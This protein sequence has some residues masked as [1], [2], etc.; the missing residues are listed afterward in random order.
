M[1]YA[2][3]AKFLSRLDIK[4]RDSHRSVKFNFKFNQQKLHRIASQM[5]D[6]GRPVRLLVDKARRVTC[7]SWVEGISFCHS[8]AIPGAHSL[9]VAHEFKTSKELF[10]V[11][12][13]FLSSVP[14]LGIEAIEREIR[15]PHPD[16]PSVMQIVTAGKSTSGRG[17]T[18]SLLH[19]SE[20]AHYES[21]DAF[22]SLLPALSNHR[23]TVGVIESTPNGREGKG[24]AF[25][26]MY[27]DAVEG[28]SSWRAVFLSWTDDPACILDETL[29]ADAP[30]DDEE[31]ELM[32]RGL[33]RA[34]LAWRR[35]KISTE[36]EGSVS[37]FH[38]EYPTTDT[39]SFIASGMPAFEL[40][41]INWARK[42]VS[43]PIRTG[44]LE[45]STD[46]TLAFRAHRDG[47]LRIW[48]EPVP[49]HYYYL[50]CDAAR[51]EEGRDF[52]AIVVFDGSTGHQVATYADYC[53]PEVLGCHVNS[54]GRFYNRAML[55]GDITGG[56]GQPALY[57]L[58]EIFRYPNLYRWK[59]RDDKLA[60]GKLSTSLWLTITSH[61]REMLFEMFRMAL[62]EA[63]ATDGDYGIILRDDQLVSQIELCT[64]RDVRIDVRKGHDDILFAAMIA[65]L[66]RHQYAPPRSPNVV[67]TK[68]DEDEAAALRSIRAR[69]DVILSE[70]QAAFRRHV[71]RIEQSIERGGE[72]EELRANRE[73]IMEEI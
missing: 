37:R 69:G 19:C 68:D 30:A 51:G 23:D 45:R 38:Q 24:E 9:I 5:A 18:L 56:Y 54:L 46:G 43:K 20:A 13:D 71:A 33:S 25:Y 40:D 62:R 67:R 7:S 34:Q 4:D 59:G 3:A 22:M 53:I 8:L 32:S 6:E 50:G 48:E 11:P 70:P 58:R 28:K 66:S 17:F 47:T 44:F 61:I 16:V 42:H 27:W 49:G 26:N 64:R 52:S 41:E 35:D 55:N 15:F 2:A 65:N 14:W 12:K 36:L 10:R 72:P 21:A 73:A 57:V 1:N 60:G 39:E 63:A 29:A 31:R